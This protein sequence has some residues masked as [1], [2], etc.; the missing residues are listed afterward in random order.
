[1]SPLP[2]HLYEEQEEQLETVRPLTTRQA[3][4][5]LLTVEAQRTSSEQ[6]RLAQLLAADPEI[7]Q[8]YEHAQ[9]VCR[10]VRVCVN[11]AASRSTTGSPV[12]VRRAPRS[13]ETSSRGCSKM[14]PPLAR[15]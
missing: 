2:D 4:R 5:L 13:C 12:S 1:M 15:V 3:A 10:L 14:K 6:T 8:A 11:D 7:A 9:G